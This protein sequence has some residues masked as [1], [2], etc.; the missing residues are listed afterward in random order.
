MAVCSV[1]VLV[2]GVWAFVIA[3]DWFDRITAAFLVVVA[4]SGFVGARRASAAS[5]S[6]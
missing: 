2:V 6:R 5:R 4:V 1:V 3:D